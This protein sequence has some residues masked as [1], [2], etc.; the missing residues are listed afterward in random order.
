MP[1]PA[2]TESA[3]NC[4]ALIIT[5]SSWDC[6]SGLSSWFVLGCWASSRLTTETDTLPFDLTSPIY[7]AQ[8]QSINQF[9]SGY[10]PTTPDPTNSNLLLG[11]AGLLTAEDSGLILEQLSEI[12]L[13]LVSLEERGRCTVTVRNNVVEAGKILYTGTLGI[14]AHGEYRKSKPGC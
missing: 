12:H 11:D 14:H 4:T 3:S 9:I 1:P 5:L 13:G 7:L 6:L 2:R 10:N 8:T